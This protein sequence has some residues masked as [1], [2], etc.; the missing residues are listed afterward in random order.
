MRIMIIIAAA[1]HMAAIFGAKQN[2]DQDR[3]LRAL[4]CK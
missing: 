1:T 3:E 4:S 2:R